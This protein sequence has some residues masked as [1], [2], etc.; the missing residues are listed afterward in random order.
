MKVTENINQLFIDDSVFCQTVV[1]YATVKVK[2]HRYFCTKSDIVPH[3][4][5]NSELTFE[6][7]IEDFSLV[8]GYD[9]E[10]I[11][12]LCDLKLLYQHVME[13]GNG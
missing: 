12:D 5:V 2:R 10:D 8:W 1:S 3:A 4:L 6:E 13:K 9:I 11:N 7:F